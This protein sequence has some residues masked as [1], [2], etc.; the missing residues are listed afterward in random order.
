MIE[1]I[2]ERKST[3]DKE[4]YRHHKRSTIIIMYLSAVFYVLLTAVYGLTKQY[5]LAWCFLILS[6][7]F[8][9][10][11]RELQRENLIIEFVVDMAEAIELE[12]GDEDE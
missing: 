3:G 1:I 9:S 10:K 4:K 5:M 12:K 6:Y 2:V 7:V 11:G 8:F